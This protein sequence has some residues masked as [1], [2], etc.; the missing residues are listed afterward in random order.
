MMKRAPFLFALLT[1]FP[2]SACATADHGDA[3]SLAKRPYEGRFDVPI[4]PVPVTP[5]G[6]LPADFAGRMERWN[7]D[8]AKGQSDFAAERD[9]AVRLVSAANG[10]SQSSEA[11]VV[12][13]QA[14]SRLIAARAPATAALADIDRLYL[15]RSADEAFDGMPQIYALR[16]RLTE[17]VSAQDAIIDSLTSSLK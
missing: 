12:A 16:E 5:P 17:M 14:I 11:W 1:V 13:Q 7:A 6:P 10:A 9:G 2:L 4:T 15:D 8:A 3:P